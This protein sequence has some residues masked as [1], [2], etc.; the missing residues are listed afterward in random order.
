MR[1]PILKYLVLVALFLWCGNA[2]AQMSSQ[3]KMIAPG[4]IVSG[5]GTS[6]S[7]DKMVTGSIPM[8]PT[9]NSAGQE[10]IMS[11]GVVAATFATGSFFIATYAGTSIETVDPVI[12]LL[13]VAH[14]GG[15][16]NVSGIFYHRPGG[17]STFIAVN[18]V[19]GTGDTLEYAMPANLLSE[20]G[21]EYYFSV[22]NGTATSTLGSATLPYVFITSLTNAQGP[23]TPSASYRIVGVPINITGTKTITSVFEDD[24]GTYNNTVWRMAAY[25]TTA[26]TIAEHTL[27]TMPQ[28][29]A[30]RGYWLITKAP[31]TYGA[32]GL[33][34]RPNRTHNGNQYYEISLGEVGWNQLANPLP[35]DVDWTDV[36]VDSGGIIQTGHPASL[37][38]D[39][40]YSYNGSGYNL[41]TTIPA[42]GGVFVF[43]KE[44]I[45]LLF[46]YQEGTKKSAPKPLVF[47]STKGTPEN[48]SIN[49]RMTTATHVDDGNTIGVRPGALT[50]DDLFD[51]AEPPP[52][53]GAPRLF[54]R[55][56]DENSLAMRTDFRAPFV[57][58]AIWDLQIS[59][60]AERIIEFDGLTNIPDG[61]VAYFV[62][63][64]GKR[65]PLEEGT[66]IKLADVVTSA[67]II[68]GNQKFV[69]GEISGSLPNQY[70]L[71]QNY[72]NPFNP[73]TN[74]DFALPQSGAVTL[75][76]FNI[77]GQTVAT[78]VDE[79]MEAGQY[80]IQWDGSDDSGRP[81]ASGI[82]FYRIS[83][84]TYSHC[85][86]MAL[87]K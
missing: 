50:G 17:A 22:T 58:G 12:Q 57:D 19:A 84:G 54:F 28:A 86:K 1:K 42:W 15:S 72:P 85:L 36:L 73:T 23:A 30:G 79:E 33:S 45:K 47:A 26:D 35:F 37:L 49:I 51:F 74:I 20:R 66:V 41:V 52:A 27:Q 16:G 25:M 31:D 76:V 78:L 75:A 11:G 87:L 64:K 59:S 21:L 38:N 4:A 7:L 2:S 63:E 70:S 67:T 62:P 60:A 39:F 82:Y 77:L 34:M 55:L 10:Y 43:T 5:G 48:W 9:G 68:V 53:P 29:F 56:A 61:M 83:S 6:V 65:V 46:P 8:T 3:D 40:A 44:Q 80:S 24:F 18:M 71:S 69:S 81:V 14:G 32:T 13:K